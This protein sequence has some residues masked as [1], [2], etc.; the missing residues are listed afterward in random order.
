MPNST[1][2]MEF[3]LMRFS[4]VW[5]LQILHS[6]SFFMLYLVTLM[7]NILIVTVTTCDSSLHMPMY[8]FLRNLSILDACYI[9][10]TVPTSC[11]NSLLDSTTISKAGCVAQ[12]FLVVFFVYV[13]LL[14]LTIMAH[15]RY[16]AVCQPLHYPVIVNSRICIQMTLASLLSGLV[17]AGMHTGSTFQLPFC[18]SNVIHQF[19]CDIP[20]LLKLSCS[21][22]F[23][24]EV[25]IVVSALGVGGGC[26]IFIIRSYIHIFSTVLGFP[27]GADRTKAFSTCIPHILVVSV[28][29]SSCSSVYLRPP[30]IPA[31]TQDL[32]LSGFYSIMPPLFNP[33][34]YSLRNK[35]IKVAIKK[36]MKRIFYSENV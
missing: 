11:V 7:G 35:Q 24:N 25:M 18:R 3:L 4:D 22:T 10:V 33:I 19:F 23:S 27:R 21:D 28:F 26:F 14:F 8:F 17:Y 29:L 13:E 31:A 6:A 1:T 30:A 36:I 12:V 16:V 32:I 34:I 2:V 5:T 15:D 20:S 9:S